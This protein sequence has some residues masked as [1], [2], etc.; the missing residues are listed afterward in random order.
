M[1]CREITMIVRCI[2]F[3]SILLVL[4]AP[5]RFILC[6]LTQNECQSIVGSRFDA[7]TAAGYNYTLPFPKNLTDAVLEEAGI[8]V[9][10]ILSETKNCS[11][12]LVGETIHCA[13]LIPKCLQG[14]RELP[15]K[16]VCGEFLKQCEKTLPQYGFDFLITSC[17]VLPEGNV[18]SGNCFEPPNFKTNDS[19]SGKF[20]VVNNS[21]RNWISWRRS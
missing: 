3:S 18:S 1:V 8:I 9:N 15:C 14:K 20:F 2:V 16:R 6:E 4:N 13:F 17:H 19:E 10:H 7:C 12:N 11:Q 21:G 5:I